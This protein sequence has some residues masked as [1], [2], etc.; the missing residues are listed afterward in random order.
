M[1]D[2]GLHEVQLNGKQLVFL[3]IVGTVFVVVVFLSGVMVGRGLRTPVSP[4]LE[5]A[6]GASTADPT[7]VGLPAASP[8]ADGAP[9]SAGESLSYAERLESPSPARETLDEPQAPADDPTQTLAAASS[10]TA[11]STGPPSKA[12]PVSRPS[13]PV[14]AAPAASTR[15][16]APPPPPPAATTAL[17]EPAGSGFVVQVMAVNTRTEA[18]TIAKRLASKGYPTFVTTTGAGVKVSYRVRVGKYDDKREA[19]A[20]A[21][22]LQKEEQFNPWVTR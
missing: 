20:V 11:P 16:S 19:D 7:L 4:D 13:D 12:Q 2:E 22:R 5:N 15:A 14:A 21:A 10:P 8:S 17:S 3:F 18:D 6:S 1:A 9:V